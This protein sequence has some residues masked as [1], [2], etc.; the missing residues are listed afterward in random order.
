MSRIVLS[1]F[2][3]SKCMRSYKLCSYKKKSVFLASN[4]IRDAVRKKFKLGYSIYK[5]RIQIV[6]F[7]VS[8]NIFALDI[9]GDFS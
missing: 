4:R 2:E 7:V 5:M 9:P 6:D 8:I 1:F 3:Q